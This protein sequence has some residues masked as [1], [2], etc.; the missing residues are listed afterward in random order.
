M[1]KSFNSGEWA[2]QLYSRVD[3]EKY[4]SGAAL[5]E[6]F[7]V[8]YR[9]GASTRMGTRYVLQGYQSGYPIRL[10]PFQ[11][12]FA[13][14]YILEF[15]QGYIR[16]FNNGAPV[17]Q[18][19]INITGATR[20]N[21]CVLSATNS[22][23][24]G[25]WIFIQGVGGMTQLNG[26]Y[27]QVTSATG[28][29]ITLADLFGNPV[30][31]TAFGTY[32][33]GG[34]AARVYIIGT[35]YAAGDLALLKYTQNVNALILTHS[36]YPAQ[37]LTLVSADVWTLLPI[38]YGT[39]A[40]SPSGLT[41]TTTLSAG[42]VYY[43]YQVTS[44]SADGEES[45]ASAPVS[46]SAYQDLRTVAGSNSL[47]CNATPG[48]ASFNWY[49]SDVSYFGTLPVGIPYGFIGNTAGTS[50]ID[51]N[52]DPDYSQ[53]PPIA[54]DP[55]VGGSL[56]SITVTAPGAYTTVPTATLSGSAVISGAI[57]PSLGIVPGGTLAS[58]GGDY[59]IGDTITLPNGAVFTVS[60][61]TGLGTV[62][63]IILTNSG[64][65][66][67]GS[68]PTNPI[69]QLTTSGHG[70]GFSFNAVWGV[71]NVAVIIDGAGYTAA[72]TV[73]FSSGSAAAT[74]Y[75][76]MVGTNP[77]GVP[78]F[79]QQ[80]LILAAPNNS[81]GELNFSQPGAPYNFDISNP[82]QADDAISVTLASGQLET[83]KSL[84]STA[85]GL[86]V[87]TDK[88]L[89]LVNGGGL[90]TAI[91]PSSI[92]ANRQSNNGA[93]DMPPILNN[94]D[95]L[96][97]DGKGPV[98]R[99]ATYNYY[100]QVFTGS[101]TSVIASHLFFGYELTEWAWAQA[102]FKIV[103]LVRNDGTM[104][105]L[106]FAKEQ[107]F[108]A[109]AHHNTLG[110]FKSVATVVETV[111]SGVVDAVYVV[112]QREINGQ[113]LQY[114]ERFVERSF[115]VTGSDAWCVDAGIQYSGTATLA[116]E[117]ASHLAACTVTG[118]ATDNLGNV[119][120]ISPF[121]MPING[122]FNLPAPAGATGYTTVTVGLG[123]N[124]LLQTLSIDTGEP[125]IQAKMKKIPASTIRV[126][127]TL[128]LEIG[129]SFDNLVPMHDLILGSV[130]SMTNEVVTG[131][132]TG[133][134][135]TFL[136]PLWQTA[137]Q[138]CIQ[139]SLPY[140]ATITGVVPQLAVGDTR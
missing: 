7:F 43:S 23:H 135:R 50:L 36:N 95:V 110:Y 105:S 37:V 125:T 90:G 121:T 24:L 58:G 78:G 139:Q 41:V 137:G 81:P 8:D 83:I 49:K 35:P 75:I 94:Y 91:S 25:D 70:T 114:I 4:H 73:V 10:I 98:V 56:T 131:L 97:V 106:T 21:P 118:L 96:Y 87:F 86:I 32:T 27:Y 138:F 101:D 115:S 69:T 5:L 74:A 55:F 67:A 40:Q 116:F 76:S 100:A 53:T 103:W 102:P 117:G 133:D 60:G 82:I 38:T 47:T 14:S 92:V 16:F 62:N 17:L 34:T 85:P 136:D 9:G 111:P 126:V 71:T 109:W 59:N 124:A 134:A 22:Y 2:P 15:G 129:T 80:R 66:G 20:A 128:G 54:Q 29:T 89:W 52:L 88:A 79:H 72:P 45:G 108:I 68:T 119:S 123:F 28:S 63:T 11:A 46:L 122:E 48:A 127:D 3:I 51:S 57:A 77:P 99:N 140:P 120:V 31:S 65:L 19:P 6:N 33:S 30:D 104:L 107:E 132:V 39:S 26:N 61:V 112:V 113:S 18:S 130:G 93:N 42:T 84:L 1:Q 12:S 64:N 44:V 13:V